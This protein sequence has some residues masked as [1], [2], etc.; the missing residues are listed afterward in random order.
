MSSL[1]KIGLTIVKREK[2]NFLCIEWEY[3]LFRQMNKHPN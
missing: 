2:N 1:M 3:K